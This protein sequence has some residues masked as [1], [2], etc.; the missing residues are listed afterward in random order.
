MYYTDSTMYSVDHYGKGRKMS[1]IY[2][3]KLKK[4]YI[5]NQ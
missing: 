2:F 5:F 1:Y 3:S 4:V